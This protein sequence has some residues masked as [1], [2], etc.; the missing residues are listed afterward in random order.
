[1]YLE[2]TG[3]ITNSVGSSPAYICTYDSNGNMTS[4]SHSVISSMTY[5]VDNMPIAATV[6]GAQ[7]VYQRVEYIRSQRIGSSHDLGSLIGTA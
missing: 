2:Q 5:D 4:D 7:V 6:N 3:S 1:M